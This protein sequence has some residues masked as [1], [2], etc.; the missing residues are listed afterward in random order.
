MAFRFCPLC[1]LAGGALVAGLAATPMLCC[2]EETSTT[3]TITSVDDVA[4][5]AKASMEPLPDM[6]AGDYDIDPVHSTVLFRVQHLGAGQFWGRFNDVRGT[7]TYAE[8]DSSAPAFSLTI[9]VESVD[10]GIEK[11]SRYPFDEALLG[12][13]F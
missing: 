5:G 3:A 10:T 4:P 9:P 8:D 2:D 1:I 7:V 13:E 11:L 12:R 6:P